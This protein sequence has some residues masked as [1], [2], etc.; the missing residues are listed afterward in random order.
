MEDKERQDRITRIVLSRSD[1]AAD[2]RPEGLIH[3]RKI[4]TVLEWID[5]D[6][7]Q[8][9]DKERMRFNHAISIIGD[10]GSGKTTFLRTLK[11]EIYRKRKNLYPLEIIDPTLI[12][13][14]A[15]P[16]LLVL[17]LIKDA[18]YNREENREC[19]DRYNYMRQ[20]WESLL[21]EL[22][23]GLPSIEN[24]SNTF[25]E[26]PSWQDPNFIMRKGL[27]AVRSACSIQQKFRE[28][29]KCT[30]KVLEKDAFVI[31]LDDI[32]IDFKK[33]WPVLEMIRKY[34]D[35]PEIFTIISG[36]LHLFSKAVRK[37]Q[38]LN[39]GKA[40]LKNEVDRWDKSD[41]RSEQEYERL[42][43]NMEQ[44]YMRKVLRPDRMIILPY[45]S[46]W[47]DWSIN[48]LNTIHIQF[49]EQD[50]PKPILDCYNEILDHYGIFD[51]QQKKV[52]ISSILSLTI[53]TQVQFLKGYYE[54]K[55]KSTAKFILETFMNEFLSSE[56]DVFFMRNR[57]DYFVPAIL[58]FLLREDILKDFY[59]LRPITGRK[60][61]DIILF[62][63]TLSF[64]RRVP[65][66]REMIFDYWIRICYLRNLFPLKNFPKSK[67]W[68]GLTSNASMHAIV[69]SIISRNSSS[70]K[71]ALASLRVNYVSS[72]KGSIDLNPRLAAIPFSR[73][74]FQG[75]GAS[76]YVCSIMFIIAVIYDVLLSRKKV[77][78][79]DYNQDVKKE[80][81]NIIAKKIKDYIKIREYVDDMPIG[82]GQ[83]DQTEQYDEEDDFD[84]EFSL[85]KSEQP[86]S[87]LDEISLIACLLEDWCESSFFKHIPPY[88]LGRMF[89]NFSFS[90][91]K[92]VSQYPKSNVG[93]FLHKTIIA[94]MNSVLYEEVRERLE[95]VSLSEK[96][97]LRDSAAFRDNIVELKKCIVYE[98]ESNLLFSK[99]ILSCPLFLCFLNMKDPYLKNDL[100]YFKG[101]LGFDEDKINALEKVNQYD[102]LNKIQ[103]LPPLNANDKT[104]RRIK[105]MRITPELFKYAISYDKSNVGEKRLHNSVMKKLTRNFGKDSL[106]ELKLKDFH[107]YYSVF[108]D[109]IEG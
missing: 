84:E 23:A 48:K 26:D 64:S 30:L 34:L 52:F 87:N 15:H 49:A 39:F 91:K 97:P 8:K 51:F 17:S 98:N 38:W 4:E 55:D 75:K 21:E 62:A 46:E 101:C 68:N 24:L 44:Q 67:D 102:F 3:W 61:I 1:N 106:S 99:W 82:Q 58:E 66:K 35:I 77:D 86:S 94:L 93:D 108:C 27:N 59:Q 81:E 83:P 16:F 65:K 19:I 74:V 60:E 36:E 90:A 53:R 28:L 103:E 7:M 78:S 2:F 11:G 80:N 32:D 6:L 10:R 88:L 96:Q 105:N 43:T 45:L 92:I 54:T 109:K 85:F 100:D 41:R 79:G 37:Q 47:N 72:M 13:E 104:F 89:T 76:V 9:S 5:A 40:L 57:S 71:L 18:F 70:Q 25:R 50:L 33:G 107:V 56:V 29:V 14:K 22:A 42:V 95:N 73:I 12:E 31:F 63:F 20:H 69:G